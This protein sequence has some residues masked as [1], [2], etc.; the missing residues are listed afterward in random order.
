MYILGFPIELV[1]LDVD[2]VIVDILGEFCKEPAKIVHGGLRKNLEEAASHFQLPC[3]PIAKSIKE[4][5]QGIVRIRGNARDSTRDMWPHLTEEQITEFISYFHEV[6]RRCPYALIDGALEVITLLR[7]N[8]IPLAIATN[9]PMKSLLWRLEAAGIDPSWF[10]TV[11][12]KDHQYFKPHPKTF[13]RI[14]QH[15]GVARERT[16]YV[17]DLQIDWDMAREASVLFCAVLT[18]GVPRDAF[19]AEGVPC[20]HILDRLVDLVEYIKVQDDTPFCV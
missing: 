5:M 18:G 11:V 10:A 20:T 15:V 3:E 14:F 16:L 8:G 1:I 4:V 17:G 12:T 9:N 13:D 7:D 6:E 19:L 2:G